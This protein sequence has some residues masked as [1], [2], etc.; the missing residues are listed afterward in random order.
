MGKSIDLEIKPSNDLATPSKKPYYPSVHISKVE[1]DFSVGDKVMLQCV[2]K[3]ATEEDD[4]SYSCDLEAQS[5][6]MGSGSN[7]KDAGDG[8]DS[9]LND[10]SKKKQE[11]DA[12]ESDEADAG[13]DNSTEETD[14]E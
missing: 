12:G 13:M 3:R 14:E 4:G 2:V 1:G 11:S 6:S 8:L 10:I 9:A 7:K 5:M